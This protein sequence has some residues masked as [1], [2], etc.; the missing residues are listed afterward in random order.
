MQAIRDDS[1]DAAFNAV[2]EKPLAPPQIQQTS[3]SW[4]HLVA[5]A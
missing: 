5:G 4:T 3:S 2:S 1:K